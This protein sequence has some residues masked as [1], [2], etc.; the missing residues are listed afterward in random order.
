MSDID[1]VGQRW[2]A[3]AERFLDTARNCRRDGDLDGCVSRAQYA[4]LHTILALV[5]EVRPYHSYTGIADYFSGHWTTEHSEFKDVGTLD[6]ERNLY[7]SLM[8]LRDWRE[9][10]DYKLGET[11]EVR[12]DNALSFTSRFIEKAKEQS[13]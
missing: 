2:L 1:S 11:V 3:K 4:I 5:P 8:K 6:N 9:D 10:A 7:H 12:A 13:R